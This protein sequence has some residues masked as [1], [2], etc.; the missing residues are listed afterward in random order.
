MIDSTPKPGKRGSLQKGM[1]VE[2]QNARTRRR[3][4]DGGC[5]YEIPENGRHAEASAEKRGVPVGCQINRRVLPGL[6]APVTN[7]LAILVPRMWLAANR[8]LP[9]DAYCDCRSCFAGFPTLAPF[10]PSK[11]LVERIA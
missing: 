10:G 7:Q 1:N 3:D 8:D 11:T 5:I 2:F 4:D 9:K 6:K